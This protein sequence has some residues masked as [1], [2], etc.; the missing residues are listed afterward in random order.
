MNAGEAGKTSPVQSR[1]CGSERHPPLPGKHSSAHPKA[2]LPEASEGDRPRL[3]DR[4][5][6]PV[7]GD[8]VSPGGG[9]GIPCQ[10]VR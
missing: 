4:S 7:S 5:A 3:Q 6:V 9:G 2:A 8:T 10:A 1:D